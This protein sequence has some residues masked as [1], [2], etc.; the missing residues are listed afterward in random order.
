MVTE[1]PHMHALAHIIHAA[2]LDFA[3]P[4]I[5]LPKTFNHM[6]DYIILYACVCEKSR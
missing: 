2:P 5:S 3:D 6:S 1:H 4:Q